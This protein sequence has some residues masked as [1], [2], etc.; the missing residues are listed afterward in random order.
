MSIYQKK[1][2]VKQEMKSI[3]KDKKND[4]A[5]YKYAT[6]SAINDELTPLLNAHGLLCDVSVAKLES[7]KPYMSEH[8][9]KTVPLIVEYRNKKNVDV[10]I[11]EEFYTFQYWVRATLTLIEAETGEKET[12][13]YDFLCDV[14]QANDIQKSGSTMTY[15][16][17]YALGAY[18][19]LAFDDDDP[20]HTNNTPA[21]VRNQYEAQQGYQAPAQAPK[22]TAPPPDPDAISAAESG[23][24][25]ELCKQA[26]YTTEKQQKD[27]LAD[28]GL[29]SF[30]G[31][32]KDKAKQLREHL[33]KDFNFSVKPE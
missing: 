28:F 17:R 9:Q 10:S 33:E 30:R 8:I 6:L 29:I 27:L 7:E 2:A 18:F 20:D 32:P 21:R 22:P 12:R 11:I 24:L 25:F 19:G 1:L 13:E 26:G 5:K 14:Q 16:Q 31:M 15:A 3:S 23:Q 4:F